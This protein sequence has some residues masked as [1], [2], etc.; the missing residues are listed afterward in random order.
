MSDALSSRILERLR[1]EADA[2]VR[3]KQRNATLD[4]LVEACNDITSGKALAIIKRGLPDVEVNFRRQPV[5]L[6]PIRIQEYVEARLAIDVTARIARSEW[7][8]PRDLTIR[9]D[10]GLYEYVQIR[11]QEQLAAN[12][13]KLVEKVDRT[14]DQVEDL[15]LR[16]KLRFVLAHAR[17]ES[18]DLR[19]LK[20]AMRKMRPTID[21]DAIIKG[22][23]PVDSSP[24]ASNSGAVP[25]LPSPADDQNSVHAVTAV[26]KLQNS[27]FLSKC[28]LEYSPEFGNVF[29]S[30]TRFELITNEELVALRKLTGVNA[31]D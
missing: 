17:Q 20:A 10:P 6:I 9:K 18:N 7:T 26:L 12:P 23:I 14:L 22:I 15:A 4:R 31:E 19:R 27:K 8:G 21:V 2:S 29:E 3:P 16:S 11:A 5:K 28:G 24:S 13:G 30:K 25:A 1:S